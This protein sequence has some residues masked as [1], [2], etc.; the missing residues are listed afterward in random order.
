MAIVSVREAVNLTGLSTATLYRHIK[1]GKLSRTNEGI[2]TAE[3]LRA[4]GAFKTDTKEQEKPQENQ[5]TVV[6]GVD[7]LLSQITRL[8]N[9]L[10]KAEQS[11]EDSRAEVMRLAGIIDKRLSPPEETIKAS[12]DDKPTLLAGLKSLFK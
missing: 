5:Q 7:Y 10:E 9:R 2:D 6:V 4:Y 11:A 3:L 12:H 8:E 1:Q